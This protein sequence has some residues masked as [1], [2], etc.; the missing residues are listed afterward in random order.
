[1]V[2]TFQQ[3]WT[4]ELD[5]SL[6]CRLVSPVSRVTSCSSYLFTLKISEADAFLR[7]AMAVKH[8]PLMRNKFGRFGDP[9][10]TESGCHALRCGDYPSVRPS[11][12]FQRLNHASDFHENR[13]SQNVEQL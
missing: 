1:M 2:V 8:I 9:E 11:V 12:T 4:M 13:S 10:C 5:A 3:Q 7:V 6:H